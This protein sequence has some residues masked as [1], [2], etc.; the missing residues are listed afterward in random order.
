MV[1]F[2]LEGQMIGA[3]TLLNG[4]GLALFSRLND[5][6]VLDVREEGGISRLRH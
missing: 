3:F 5:H 6:L 4:G 1:V 2:L